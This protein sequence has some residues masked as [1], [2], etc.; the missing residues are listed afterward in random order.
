MSKWLQRIKC[1]KWK[2]FK[3]N[4]TKHTDTSTLIIVVTTLCQR[5]W[6]NKQNNA[7]LQREF[8]VQNRHWCN[9]Y[10]HMDA[11][12]RRQKER[13]REKNRN[14]HTYHALFNVQHS[15]RM[16]VIVLMIYCY[17]LPCCRSLPASTLLLQILA[18]SEKELRV[19]AFTIR[20]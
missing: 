16:L 13:E 20:I 8:S 11:Q 4:K 19:R 18:E 5:F 14:R 3:Q 17:Y 10:K 7:H 15:Y 12:T 1:S 6:K 2:Q 9:L